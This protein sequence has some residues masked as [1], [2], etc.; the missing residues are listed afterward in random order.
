MINKNKILMYLIAFMLGYLV[1]RMMRG[2]GFNIGIV[3]YGST[4][5]VCKGSTQNKSIEHISKVNIPAHECKNK[6]DVMDNTCIGYNYMTTPDEQS[7]ICILYGDPLA[8]RDTKLRRPKFDN[9]WK[10]R[11]GGDKPIINLKNTI[12]DNSA[13]DKNLFTCYYKKN[14]LKE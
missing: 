11:K 5:G 4:G 3:D 13:G 8:H 2:D 7:S 1:S 9:L 6:C 14:L 10:H 12:R